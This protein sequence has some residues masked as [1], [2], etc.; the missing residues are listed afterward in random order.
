MVKMKG[1]VEIRT[2]R[3][4]INRFPVMNDNIWVYAMKP[5]TYI[6]S[7]FQTYRRVI[8]RALWKYTLYTHFLEVFQS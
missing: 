8:R 6:Q 2:I 3:I 5:F 1:S 7:V 4:L